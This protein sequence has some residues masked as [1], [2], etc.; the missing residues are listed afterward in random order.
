[1]I[2]IQIGYICPLRYITINENHRLDFNMSYD[3]N[4]ESSVTIK[5]SSVGWNVFDHIH[6][7]NKYFWDKN[8]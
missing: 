3:N 5:A 7:G 2:Q 1:M 4:Y 6:W 8:T